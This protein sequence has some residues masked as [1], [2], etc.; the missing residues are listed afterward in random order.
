[1]MRHQR[2]ALIVLG[3]P[4]SRRIAFFQTAAARLGFEPP[5]VVSYADFVDG[6]NSIARHLEADCVLRIESPGEDWEVERRL[7]TAGIEPLAEE[8]GEPLS[9]ARIQEQEFQAGRILRPRQWYLGFL[10]VLEEL[11][12][13]IAGGPAVRYMAHPADI[14]VLFDKTQ[15]QRRWA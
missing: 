3:N 5:R 9:F 8:G 14:P 1:M 15:C 10:K 4:G 13:Q 2:P 12:R 6:R 11:T 7:L